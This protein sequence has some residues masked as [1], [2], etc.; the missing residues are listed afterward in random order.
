MTALPAELPTYSFVLP[1]FN[2]EETLPELHRRLS[3]LLAQLDGTAEVLLVDDGSR[4]R[5]Y[6]LMMDIAARDSRFKIISLS[7][8]FGH[9]IAITAGIDFARGQAI[10][11]MDADLQDPPEVV[12]EM[13]ARW[14]AGVD[15]VYAVREE[16][17]EDTWFKRTTASVFYNVLR[18]LTEVDIPRRPE[19][20]DW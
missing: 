18:K 17:T 9:Q 20:S 4:D 6:P 3:A 2:E 8:N 19:I 12:L 7:R 14:R 5:S 11:I 15:I 16:R 1:V 13:A 10:V